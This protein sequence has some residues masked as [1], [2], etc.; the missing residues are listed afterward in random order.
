MS[1]RIRGILAP[2]V[3]PFKEDLSPDAPR[4]VAH[5]R[6]LLSQNAGLAFFGTNSEAN[7]MSLVERLDLMDALFEAGLPT[8][9]MIPGTGC[10]AFPDTVELTRKAVSAGCAGVLMLPPFFYKNQSDDGL[11][12][13]YSEI[14]Q[15]VGDAR[16]RIYL[17]H[18]PPVSQV[19]LPATLIE[20]LIA[21]YPKTIAGIKDSSGDAK[22]TDMLLKNFQ[23]EDFDVFCGSEVFLL[24]TLRG[25]GAGSI[26]ATG[27]VNPAMIHDLYIHWQDADADA[28][29]ERINAI[30]RAFESL[31]T[32]PAMKSAIAWKRNDP[33]WRQVRP[34]MLPVPPEKARVLQ[35]QLTAL[36]FDM[37]GLEN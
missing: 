10:C 28:R 1:K 22:H 27:N 13:S 8:S 29:Q 33:P 34:P 24:Q 15:R 11:F 18:I 4:L 7:S 21:A 6:W 9:R 31:P 25:G 23:S 2:V 37:P 14:I 36:G 26:T 5:C 35:D 20:R 16:L 19:P 32:I 30:R 12:R 17:Y 3:T